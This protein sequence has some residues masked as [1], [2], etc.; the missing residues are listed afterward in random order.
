MKH[1]VVLANEMDKFGVITLPVKLPVFAR[2]FR[3]FTCGRNI[4]YR[5][6]KPYIQHFS[7]STFDRN[8]HTPVEIARNSPRL[9]TLVNPRLAL[10]INVCFPV[11]FMTFYDPFAKPALSLIKGQK[12]M[13]GFFEHRNITTQRRAWIFQVER[14]ERSSTA[15]TL[16][17]VST[18]KATMRTGAGDVSVG[19]KLTGF[20]IVILL[21][22]FFNKNT[23][24]IKGFKKSSR[25]LVVNGSRSA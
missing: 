25:S 8:L 21:R 20:C 24:I 12:P 17:A 19:Q 6:I 13:L 22:C 4:T 7:I 16:V 3:P 9:Q 5:C 11:V 15:F 1:D 14:T 23:F 2:F 18:F 10:T